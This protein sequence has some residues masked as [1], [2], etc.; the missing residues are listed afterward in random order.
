[1]HVHMRTNCSVMQPT[2]PPQ[3]FQRSFKLSEDGEG[4]LLYDDDD[5]EGSLLKGRQGFRTGFG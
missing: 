3:T 1:M 5:D 4:C 2:G